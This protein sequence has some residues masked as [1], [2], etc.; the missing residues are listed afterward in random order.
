[1][2]NKPIRGLLAMAVVV[3]LAGCQ[4]VLLSPSGDLALRQRDLI[5]IST[6]L[7][8]IIIVPVIVLTLLFAWRY[9]ASNQNAVYDPDW[10]HSTRLELLIWA[11]PLLIIIA[12]GALTWVSTHKLD[13]FRPLDRLAA[14]RPI[15]TDARPLVIDVVALDWKWLFIYPEQGIATV[16]EVAAPVDRPIRFHITATSVMN[17]FFIPAVAGQ[18][19]AMPGMETKLQAV[20]NQPGEFEGFSANFSGDGFNGMHFVFHGMSDDAFTQWVQQAKS[21]GQA[22]GRSTY[23]KLAQPSENEPVARY[24]TVAAGLFDDIVTNCVQSNPYC[25]GRMPSAELGQSVAANFCAAPAP[26]YRRTSR[27][28]NGADH[29]HPL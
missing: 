25:M 9:R 2:F 18:I 23:L 20:V 15:P 10:D 26:Q 13:P 1:M 4:A 14:D 3:P 28:A 21:G 19:Y 27:S 5:I 8:L 6:L 12:L 22:L 16:N 11:A 7:M 24:A 17:S 29:V